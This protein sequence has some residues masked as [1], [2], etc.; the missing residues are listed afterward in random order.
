[1]CKANKGGG[2]ERDVEASRRPVVG[3][4]TKKLQLSELNT[5]STGPDW[6]RLHHV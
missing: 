3:V 4:S 6:P 1:M 5:F 2:D